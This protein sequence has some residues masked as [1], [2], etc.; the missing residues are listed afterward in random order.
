MLT[1]EEMRAEQ[2]RPEVGGVM[3]TVNSLSVE[4]IERH[5][6]HIYSTLSQLSVAD[7]EQLRDN[8]TA[9]IEQ[10]HDFIARRDTKTNQEVIEAMLP[11]TVFEYRAPDGYWYGNRDKW[12]K[13]AD[14]RVMHAKSGEAYDSD[15]FT[16]KGWTVVEVEV[17]L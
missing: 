9:V 1:S 2:I 16:A 8:L 6:I 13:L 5:G 14:V 17:E 4:D 11:G 15:E 7:A 3:V 12:V 10:Y